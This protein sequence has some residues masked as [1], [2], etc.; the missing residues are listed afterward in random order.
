V[1]RRV[2]A[3]S[4]SGPG[5]IPA[6][7]FK[8]QWGKIRFISSARARQTPRSNFNIYKVKLLEILI[9]LLLLVA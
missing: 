9:L 6:P 4:P 7:N 3:F 1:L 8:S 5:C 2:A